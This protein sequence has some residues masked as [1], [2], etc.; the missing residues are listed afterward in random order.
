MRK[1]H[2]ATLVFTLSVISAAAFADKN[3]TVEILVGQSAQ[4][5]SSDWEH[6]R[7][8]FAVHRG[9]DDSSSNATSFGLRFGYQFNPNF[10][11]E[12]SH[13]DYGDDAASN[14]LGLKAIL[15][16]N[17]KLSLNT[18]LG[19]SSWHV[20]GDRAR[21]GNNNADGRDP[22]LSFGAEYALRENIFI[23]L[24]YTLVDMSWDSETMNEFTYLDNGD[25]SRS[26]YHADNEVQVENISMSVGFRF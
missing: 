10:A 8:D 11:I 16:V 22:Y 17:D 7:D 1:I 23:G 3:L 20:G 13:M 2:S 12:F 18:R 26:V 6:Y 5:Y 14:N 25:S 9:D 4:D 15:P 24:E 19:I 21:F